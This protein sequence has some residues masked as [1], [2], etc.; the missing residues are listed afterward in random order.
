MD[1]DKEQIVDWAINYA[2][3]EDVESASKA[4]YALYIQRRK[5]EKP[6]EQSNTKKRNPHKC[7]DGSS[8]YWRH[9]KKKGTKLDEF[10][11]KE[12]VKPVT[13]VRK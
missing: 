13:E 8:I 1:L 5:Q 11:Q 12:Y 10:K 6:Q 2:S 9:K 7:K 3:Y 4:L